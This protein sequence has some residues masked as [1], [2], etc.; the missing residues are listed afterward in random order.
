MSELRE[1]LIGAVA[2]ALHDDNNWR[3]RMERLPTSGHEFP[4]L[5]LGALAAAVVD[6]LGVERVTYTEYVSAVVY[7]PAT[8]YRIKA[9]EETT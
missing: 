4:A 7:G 9:L 1:K 3:T 8:A 2:K 5:D 6:A